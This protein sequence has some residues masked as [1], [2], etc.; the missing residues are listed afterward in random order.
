VKT[1]ELLNYGFP[2]EIIRIWEQ[3]ESENLLPV[4][5]KAIAQGLLEGQSMII[6]APTSSGKTF[7]G[8]IAA[9]KCAREGRRVIYLAPH[10]AIVDEKYHDFKRKYQEYGIRVAYH[11]EK[12]ITNSMMIF[13]KTIMTWRSSPTRSWP[14]S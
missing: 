9:Y 4:Q 3:A 8:E 14:C 1:R 6:V 2:E 11:A 5:E 10:R 13:G 7:L 12:T